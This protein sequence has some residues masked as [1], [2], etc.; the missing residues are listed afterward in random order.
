MKLQ[1]RTQ[2]QNAPRR[3]LYHKYSCILLSYEFGLTGVVTDRRVRQVS[4]V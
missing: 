1:K 3:K 4:S 2:Q